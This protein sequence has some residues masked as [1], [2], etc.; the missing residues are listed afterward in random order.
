[1]RVDVDWRAGRSRGHKLINPNFKHRGIGLSLVKGFLARDNVVIATSRK[2]NSETDG[3]GAV[4]WCSV[5]AET[6]PGH[7]Q[8]PHTSALA[9]DW[10]PVGALLLPSAGGGVGML[11]GR[12]RRQDGHTPPAAPQPVCTPR[13]PGSA[14]TQP[15]HSCTHASVQVSDAAELQ[16]LRQQY[17]PARLH[18]SDLDA[19]RAASIAQW[20][21]GVKG[22]GVKHVDVSA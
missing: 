15:T 4:W 18:L 11:S 12:A 16:Q 22:A 14:P 19:S 3:Q 17:G 21:E 20:A 10:V 2:V 8:R 7:L 6:A 1:M 13:P 5:A 9:V